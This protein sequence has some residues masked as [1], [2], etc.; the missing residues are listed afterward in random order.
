M[1]KALTPAVEAS[2][3]LNARVLADHAYPRTEW[4]NRPTWYRGA[5]MDDQAITENAEGLPPDTDLRFAEDTSRFMAS[6]MT[7]GFVADLASPYV[8]RFVRRP[9]FDGVEYQPSVRFSL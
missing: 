7:R 6:A 3:D 9:G 8:Q 4:L 1:G 2:L 5:V